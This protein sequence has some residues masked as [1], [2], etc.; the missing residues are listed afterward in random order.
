MDEPA[1]QSAKGSPSTLEDF[2]DLMLPDARVSSS[3][4]DTASDFSMER[5]QVLHD[6]YHLSLKLITV[7]RLWLP[8]S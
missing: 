4:K 3:G 2:F 5:S 8:A 1:N 6:T 7:F